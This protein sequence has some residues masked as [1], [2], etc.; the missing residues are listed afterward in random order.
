M[1]RAQKVQFLAQMI[2]FSNENLGNTIFSPPEQHILFSGNFEI[3][4][5]WPFFW[6]PMVILD[7]MPFALHT[8]PRL[9]KIRPSPQKMKNH[10]NWICCSRGWKTVCPKFSA[11][12]SFR[13]VRKLSPQS[14]LMFFFN[15]AVSC[16][17]NGV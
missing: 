16:F 5:C 17:L 6:S 10:Q 4:D 9:S 12:N 15:Q 3:Y 13:C 2:E 8:R 11:K 14:R 7:F 1:R